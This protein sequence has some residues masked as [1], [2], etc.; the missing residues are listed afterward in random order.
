MFQD[1]TCVKAPMSKE[2]TILVPVREE[3]YRE[4]EQWRAEIAADYR[5]INLD[6]DSFINLL[7]TRAHMDVAIILWSPNEGIEALKDFRRYDMN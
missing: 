4:I 1:S 5:L 7:L 6:M 2:E 3:L